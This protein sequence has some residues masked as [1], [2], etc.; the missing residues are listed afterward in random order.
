M[1]TI[2][3]KKEKKTSVS[4]RAPSLESN[5][6]QVLYYTNILC[7]TIKTEQN[8]NTI[9]L[10]VYYFQIKLKFE[11]KNGKAKEGLKIETRK[12]HTLDTNAMRVQHACFPIGVARGVLSLKKNATHND[13][14]SYWNS[15]RHLSLL[16]IQ[17]THTEQL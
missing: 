14:L 4:N 9:I 5:F 16:P 7:K 1:Y 15:I 10:Y 2:Q 17:P 13:T 8:N 3:Y 6:P 11:H 12:N